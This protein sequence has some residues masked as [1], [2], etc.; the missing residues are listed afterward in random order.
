[1]PHLHFAER[2]PKSKKISPATRP[3]P[4]HKGLK[5]QR[6]PPLP[7]DGSGVQERTHASTPEGSWGPR[8]PSPRIPGH[9]LLPIPQQNP[10]GREADLPSRRNPG[11]VWF[12]IHLPRKRRSF[13]CDGKKRTPKNPKQTKPSPS[14]S[15]E[16]K[17]SAESSSTRGARAWQPEGRLLVESAEK[18][19]PREE[20]VT[21]HSL[22]PPAESSEREG[23]IRLRS[24]LGA[25]EDAQPR[26]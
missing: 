24:P 21:N 1:M 3:Q 18:F 11:E 12:S 2:K 8:N 10:R 14:L 26:G 23:W 15:L 25:A 9:P 7:T 17:A 16:Q 20:S 5:A 4:P 22:K 6:S 19:G 13:F